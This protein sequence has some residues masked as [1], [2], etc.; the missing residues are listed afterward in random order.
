[1]K[2]FAMMDPSLADISEDKLVRRAAAFIGGDS[3]R[4]AHI[5][6]TY[7]ASRPGISPGDLWTA[8]STDYIFTIPAVRLAERQS[9]LGNDVYVYRFDWATP[10]FGGAL[11]ACHA[12][13]IPFMFNN[14][15]AA[16]SS[17]FTGPASE[18]M[19]AMALRMHDAWHTFARTGA[20]GG[21]WPTYTAGERPVMQFNLESQVVDDPNAAERVAWE[22]VL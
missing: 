22:G 16:G 8:L 17:M 19:R 7:R 21:D 18:E 11:G 14:L 1:M 13:E 9:A 4:A 10:V 2:L 3:D 6:D 15:D 12:L 5:V 20:P